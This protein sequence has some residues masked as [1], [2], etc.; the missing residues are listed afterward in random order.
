MGRGG[1]AFGGG[2]AALVAFFARW[3]MGASFLTSSSGADESPLLS[4]SDIV[5]VGCVSWVVG[6]VAMRCGFS[7]RWWRVEV[8]HGAHERHLKSIGRANGRAWRDRGLRIM[9]AQQCVAAKCCLLKCISLKCFQPNAAFHLH[10]GEFLVS[11]D[12]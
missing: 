2:A 7:C 3:K 8:G 11:I 1:E 9:E 5:A 6:V 10:Q 4:E 12:G